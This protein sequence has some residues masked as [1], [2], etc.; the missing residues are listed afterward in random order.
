MAFSNEKFFKGEPDYYVC[1]RNKTEEEKLKK[2]YINY[3]INNKNFDEDFKKFVQI[4]GNVKVKLGYAI[5][6]KIYCSSITMG[7]T[8]KRIVSTVTGYTGKYNSSSDSVS[9]S[10]NKDY[11]YYDAESDAYFSDYIIESK[12]WFGDK[13]YSK[14][15]ISPYLKKAKKINDIREYS[16]GNFKDDDFIRKAYN[17]APTADLEELT[18]KARDSVKNVWFKECWVSEMSVT[19]IPIYSITVDY[20]NNTYSTGYCLGNSDDIAK[21]IGCYN[22]GKF[23]E[24]YLYEKYVREQTNLMQTKAKRNVWIMLAFQ[25]VFGII[26]LMKCNVKQIKSIGY[27]PII[28]IPI[29]LF[30]ITA[31]ILFLFTFIY[32]FCTAKQVGYYNDCKGKR[33]IYWILSALLLAILIF[34]YIAIYTVLPYT[35]VDRIGKIVGKIG[36]FMPIV[37]AILFFGTGIVALIIEKFK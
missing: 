10:E 18:R 19:L 34:V 27:I 9:L 25:L 1:S 26:V 6:A 22:A 13:T 8:Y 31:G 29:K 15:K 3:I 30:Y 14:E 11:S 17:Y 16:D 36:D 32:G 12:A 21:G 33:T 35:P 5:C 23:S 24:Q 28:H 4:E 7:Y 2:D 20:E 37:F